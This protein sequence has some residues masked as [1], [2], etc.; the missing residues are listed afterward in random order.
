MMGTAAGVRHSRS[1]GSDRSVRAFVRGLI[2]LCHDRFP[3]EY[4]THGLG[5][6]TP[7]MRQAID[8]S[9][10]THPDPHVWS[11]LTGP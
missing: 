7:N 9:G 1:T 2:S 11:I 5:Q 3:E 6:S 8:T 4:G 10:D